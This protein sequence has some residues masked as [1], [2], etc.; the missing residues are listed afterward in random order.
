MLDSHLNGNML[1]C[2][3]L[4]MDTL[5]PC[6][7][8]CIRLCFIKSETG[9]GGGRGGF[10]LACE[11]FWRTFDH[12]FAACAFLNFLLEISSYTLVPLFIPG[13]VHSGLASSDDCGQMF[14]YK[15]CVSSFRDRFP[16]YAYTVGSRVY[17]C[18]GVTC[19]LHF[20]QN[21]QNL[22]PA[23]AVTQGHWIRISTQSWL[24]R[25]KFSG[26]S[27]WDLNFQPFDHK[28]GVLINNLTWL[29]SDTW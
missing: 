12:F 17:V 11:G 1:S 19:R 20:W 8:N 26:H 29:K 24:L 25:R 9:G 23:T 18:L 2:T 3:P 7:G 5:L 27:C 6:K 14:P 28:S 4:E 16:H 22:L 10:C 15:L 21:D 13:S